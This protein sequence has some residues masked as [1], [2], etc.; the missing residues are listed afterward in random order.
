MIRMNCSHISRRNLCAGNNQ[1][2][3]ALKPPPPFPKKIKLISRFSP[4]RTIFY[5]KLIRNPP[6]LRDE[7]SSLMLLTA[8]LGI[9]PLLLATICSLFQRLFFVIQTS[10]WLSSTW[11]VPAWRVGKGSLAQEEAGEAAQSYS[12]LCTF[13]RPIT[14]SC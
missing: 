1:A 9:A 11:K 2:I 12:S 14:G 7:M 3:S 6:L 8:V 5:A 4:L 13:Y 10:L